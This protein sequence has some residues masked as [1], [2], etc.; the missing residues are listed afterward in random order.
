MKK[1]I[2]MIFLMFVFTSM[3]FAQSPIVVFE[4]IYLSPKTEHLKEIG[5]KMKEHNQQFHATPPYN[6]SVWSVITGERSGDL[7][8]IMGPFTFTDLDSRP[9]DGG[10]DEDWRENVLPLTHGMYNGYYWKLR[11]DESYLPSEN[12]QGKLMRVRTLDLKPGKGYEFKHMMSLIMKVYDE[13]KLGNSIG[14]YNNVVRDQNRDVAIVWQYENYAYMDRDNQF[15][16]LF[17]EVHGENAMNNFNQAMRE[18]VI[19]SSDELLEI[20]PEMSIR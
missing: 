15:Q 10:H 9:S 1:P 19:S 11:P 12:F 13:K 20:I 5:E 18:I 3:V 16:K 2:Y 6:A 8:W 17:D 7:L 14:V 4:T